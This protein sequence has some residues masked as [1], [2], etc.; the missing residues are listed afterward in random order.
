M[1]GDKHTADTDDTLRQ[2]LL[3]CVTNNRTK[4]RLFLNKTTVRLTHAY[5]LVLYDL[6]ASILDFA[7]FAYG[8]M[9]SAHA[10]RGSRLATKAHVPFQRRSLAH[11]QRGACTF[12]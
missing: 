3:C 2:R 9:L 11:P 12:Y 5:L 10:S 7:N 4:R 8:K 1:H 6:Q